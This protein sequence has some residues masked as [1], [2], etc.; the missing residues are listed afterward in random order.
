MDQFTALY[1]L[2]QKQNRCK[3]YTTL[4]KSLQAENISSELYSKVPKAL[5]AGAKVDLRLYTFFYS[6][7][8]HICYSTESMSVFFRHFLFSCSSNPCRDK[9]LIP[10]DLKQG[11][12]RK[13]FL[14]D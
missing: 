11:A 8:W 9:K 7:A 5:G 12:H 2:M 6:S 10:S 14:I 1:F 3:A 4:N 13:G